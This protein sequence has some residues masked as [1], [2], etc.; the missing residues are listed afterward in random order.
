MREIW[1]AM[2]GVA[3]SFLLIY[4]WHRHRVQAPILEE[5]VV[6]VVD[7]LIYNSVEPIS[8]TPPSDL[9]SLPIYHFSDTVDGRWSAEVA[10]HGVEL[11]SLVLRESYESR[12]TTSYSAPAWEVTARG[13]LSPYSSWVGL[14]VERNIGRLQLSLGAGYDPFRSAPHVEGSVGFVLWRE[15]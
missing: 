12:R 14:G 6:E 15:Y 1:Y 2:L 8:V 10:G 3:L 9:D 13:G 7:T 4:L 5:E 11:R